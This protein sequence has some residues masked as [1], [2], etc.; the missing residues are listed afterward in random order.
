MMWTEAIFA[1]LLVAPSAAVVAW[2]PRSS[3]RWLLGVAFALTIPV[4]GPLLALVAARTR[5][6]NQ[7]EQDLDAQLRLPASEQILA[8][9][10]TRI[11]GLP[12]LLDRLMSEDRDKRLAALETLSWRCDRDAI[13][14]LRWTIKHGP[15]DAVLDAAL[16]LEELELS[17]QR[18]LDDALE[19]CKRAPCFDVSLAAADL[20]V[21]GIVNGIADPAIVDGLAAAA[22]EHYERAAQLDP[23]RADE[24]RVRRAC[25]ELDAGDPLVALQILDAIIAER[26]GACP[27]ELRDLRA[28]A[29]FAVRGLPSREIERT[30]FAR[31]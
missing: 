29:R 8:E 3:N 17:W 11:G 10:V 27:H 18:R 23:Q 19:A 21:E 14:L 7:I 9:D 16:T 26:G 30:V 15:S 25:L 20:A 22:R 28:R 4:V 5:G 31:P 12:P 1:L 2:L 24:A 13:A 6:T